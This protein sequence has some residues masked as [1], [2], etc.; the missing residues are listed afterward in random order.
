[1][2]VLLV[3]DSRAMRTLQRSV[4]AQ[5]GDHMVEE[6]RDAPGALRAIEKHAPD[7]M[8]LDRDIPGL[9]ALTLVK[10]C[11]ER[12]ASTRILVLTSDLDDSFVEAA[13]DAGASAVIEK[14]FTPD[15]LSQRIDES[16][17]RASPSAA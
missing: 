14:P 7:L 16:A 12:R 10:S 17:R 15:L 11:L 9:D 3:E 6:S 1:M 4:V 13:L 5:F 8:I 2:N